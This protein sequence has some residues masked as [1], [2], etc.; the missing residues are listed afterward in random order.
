[1]KIIHNIHTFVKIFAD[2]FS[3]FFKKSITGKKTGK[4]EMSPKATKYKYEF[5]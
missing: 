2:F 1:M 4:A 3:S 5:S